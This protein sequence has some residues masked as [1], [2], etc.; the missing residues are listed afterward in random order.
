M[1]QAQY[2]AIVIGTG[3]GGA[4][5]ACRLSQAGLKVGV[6]ERGRRYPLGGFPRHWN[7]PLDGWLWSTKQGLFD[8]RPFE[9]MMVVQSAGYGGGSLICANVHLRAIPSVFASGWPA[10]YSREVLDPYYD[11]VAYMLDIAPITTSPLGVPP[12]ATLMQQAATALGRQSVAYDR[13]GGRAQRRGRDSQSQARSQ[14][15]C[16]RA[17]GGKTSG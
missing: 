1:M 6:L 9:Q 15:D 12:K 17:R 7:D 16:S 3:F 5:S 10:N 2:D 13:G 4:V 8:V 11:L 14:L